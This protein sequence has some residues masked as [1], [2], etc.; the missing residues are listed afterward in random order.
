MIGIWKEYLRE[1]FDDQGRTSKAHI[2]VPPDF[3]FAYDVVDRIAAAEP[4]RRVLQ[5]CSVTG[6]ERTSAHS[7]R[8]SSERLRA[9]IPQT[10]V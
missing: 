2:E 1:E 10:V 5:W 7:L 3:N 9:E 4:D 6:A 8:A